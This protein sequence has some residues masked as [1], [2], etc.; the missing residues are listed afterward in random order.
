MSSKTIDEMSDDELI[1]HEDETV[2]MLEKFLPKTYQYLVGEL[3]ETVRE[4]TIREE[5]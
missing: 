1:R 3:S 4:L 5:T 2:D